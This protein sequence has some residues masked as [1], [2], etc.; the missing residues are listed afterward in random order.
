MQS[1]LAI[2]PRIM[3]Y[4]A[5]NWYYSLPKPAFESGDFFYA[6]DAFPEYVLPAKRKKRAYISSI[7]SKNEYYR[8]GPYNRRLFLRVEHG[9]YI[10]NPLMDLF[11][12]DRWTNVYELLGVDFDAAE[13][14]L[15][16]AEN[17]R[18]Y[19][20]VAV[21][22][23]QSDAPLPPFLRFFAKFQLQQDGLP[24]MDDELDIDDLF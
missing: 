16:V 4:K 14:G 15:D 12:G 3:R 13:S 9:Q 8:D 1:M 24:D 22:A 11:V 5:T 2:F 17:F 18:K 20:D 23:I 7:L 21:P 6:V 19:I 10:L